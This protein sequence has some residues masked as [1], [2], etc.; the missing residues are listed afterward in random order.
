MIT[1]VNDYQGC[2]EEY[3]MFRDNE[4]NLYS[5][6]VVEFLTEYSIELFQSEEIMLV[7][8]FS[9]FRKIASKIVTYFF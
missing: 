6:W 9:V 3:Y 1:S 7:L 4:V 8:A 2:L 5:Q